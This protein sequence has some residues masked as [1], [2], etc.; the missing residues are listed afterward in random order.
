MIVFPKQTAQVQVEE[1][2]AS[3]AYYHRETFNGRGASAVHLE[4][5]LFRSP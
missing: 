3:Y 2:H 4:V 1:S 5:P